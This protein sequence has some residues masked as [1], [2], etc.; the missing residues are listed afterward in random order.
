M[1]K[2]KIYL[3]KKNHLLTILLN[4]FSFLIDNQVHVKFLYDNG[5][6]NWVNEKTSILPFK[7]RDE[8]TEKCKVN[9][10]LSQQKHCTNVSFVLQLPANKRLK[11]YRINKC[12]KWELAVHE[13]NVLSCIKL[14]KRVEFYDTILLKIIHKMEHELRSN[15]RKTGDRC[16]TPQTFDTAYSSM[17]QSSS[18]ASL[19]P[20]LNE[21]DRKYDVDKN[22]NNY[23]I[24]VE[25]SHPEELPEE[26]LQMDESPSFAASV[27][28]SSSTEELYCRWTKLAFEMFRNDDIAIDQTA[29]SDEIQFVSNLNE[30]WSKITDTKL[31]N[32]SANTSTA[33]K[34]T[35]RQFSLDS[36]LSYSSSFTQHQTKRQRMIAEKQAALEQEQFRQLKTADKYTPVTVKPTKEEILR[37]K[38]QQIEETIHGC[39]IKSHP[40][41]FLLKGLAKDPVCQR[42]LENGDVIKCAGKCNTYLH[43]PCFSDEINES[44]YYGTLKRK[45]RKN[46]DETSANEAAT[47]IK[48]NTDKLMCIS[49][50]SP[51]ELHCFVCKKSD[52]NCIQCCDKNCGKAYHTECLKYWPQHKKAYINNTIKSLHC[53]RHVCH[54]CV[55]PDIRSMFH[56]TE[57]DKKLIKCLQC[58]GTYHRSSECIPAGSELLSETQLICARHQIKNGKRVNIDYC[59][60]CSKGGCLICCD[61]CPNSFHQDCL[62][63]PIGDHF[64]CEVSSICQSLDVFFSYFFFMLTS[65]KIHNSI[66]ILYIFE[67]TFLIGM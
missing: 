60:F 4:I 43:R 38:Q 26:D 36:S 49:C 25:L 23:L 21:L 20:T 7:S 32:S 6:R 62:K 5:R 22:I 31:A 9:S 37:K 55:S 30:L 59:L 46:N 67:N 28:S 47:F 63:V 39:Y 17:K 2:I 50:I 19:S 35:S 41:N 61:A 53:P 54:T 34:R 13:A 48:E 65:S 58:P 52:A 15:R 51:S 45:M 64:N 40:A 11:A 27:V 33:A 8:F 14:N 44:E 1:F 16:D 66:S 42:C 18:P 24:S 57:S 12:K 3:R 56:S 29:I 10:Y